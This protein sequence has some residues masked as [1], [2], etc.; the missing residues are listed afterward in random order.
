[1]VEQQEANE[2]SVLMGGHTK[3]KKDVDYGH[4]ALEG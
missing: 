4:P 3:S 2:N 1:M